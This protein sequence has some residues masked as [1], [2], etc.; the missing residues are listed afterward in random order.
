[1]TAAQLEGWSR[2]DRQHGGRHE[3]AIGR[4]SALIANVNRGKDQPAHKPED[5]MFAYDPPLPDSEELNAK[6]RQQLGLSDG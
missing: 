3:W 5:F 2:Y 1:M 4:I 6:L